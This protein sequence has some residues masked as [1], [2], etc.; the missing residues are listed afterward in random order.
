MLSSLLTILFAV[1]PARSLQ[2]FLAVRYLMTT[3]GEGALRELIRAAG[4]FPCV[5]NSGNANHPDIVNFMEESVFEKRIRAIFGAAISGDLQHLNLLLIPRTSEQEYKL[6]LYLREVARQSPTHRIPPLYLYDLLHTRSPE[7]YAYGLDRT[8]CL[9][10]RLEDLTGKPIDD[11]SLLHAIKE[12]NA[13][14]KSIHKLLQLRRQE[15]RITGT[16]AVALI[17]ASYF[18]HRDEYARLADRAAEMIGDR[19]PLAGKR[20]M[21]AK[22]FF[23]DR[24][25]WFPFPVPIIH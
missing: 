13:A 4:A 15:P 16:E 12:S 5:I 20:L 8:L 22:S 10:E 23:H 21:I 1:A 14:R 25:R 3:Y 18:M 24:T 2:S 17:G 9:K 11:A 7:S 19:R 6:Y